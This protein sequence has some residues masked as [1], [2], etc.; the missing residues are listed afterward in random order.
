LQ[1]RPLEAIDFHLC[2]ADVGVA[3]QQLFVCVVRKVLGCGAAQTG[4]HGYKHGAVEV[5]GVNVIVLK[6]FVEK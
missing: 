5:G 6:L 3:L 4:G 1:H 2:P